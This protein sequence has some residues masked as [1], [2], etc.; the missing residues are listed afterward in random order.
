[1]GTPKAHEKTMARNILIYAFA[2]EVLDKISIDAVRDKISDWF[3]DKLH[4]IKP[5]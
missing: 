3:S 1:M 2:S 5:E 4:T